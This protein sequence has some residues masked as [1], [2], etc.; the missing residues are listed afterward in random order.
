[1]V[2]LLTGALLLVGPLA[3]GS[4]FAATSTTPQTPHVEASHVAKGT[5]GKHMIRRRTGFLVLGKIVKT[6]N[7]TF[8]LSTRAGEF[9]VHV[10]DN[11]KYRNGSHSDLDKG[12][13]VAVA[14]KKKGHDIDATVVAF[15]TH[16]R[17][18]G[19]HMTGGK[20]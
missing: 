11:T 14:G 3:A 9:T 4:A 13:I 12:K 5:T 1:M 20:H 15:I 16:M 7:D 19:K 2:G 17:H 6:D 18:G 10:N 8:T